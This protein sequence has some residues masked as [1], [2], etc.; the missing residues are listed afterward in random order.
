MPSIIEGYNYDIFISYRQKDNKGDR[1]VSE[2]VEALKTELESTFKEE[3]S[4]YFDINPHDG[5]LETHDV[6]ASL[7]DK[8]KCLVFIPIIS[9]TY[10]DTKSFAWENE[11]KAFINQTSN[12]PY[13]LKINVSGGN[14]TNR[15][16]PVQIH[17]L[18]AE[19]KKLVESELGGHLRGIEFIYKES[20]V[21]RPLAPNDDEKKNLNGLKYK[22]QINKVANAIN[23]IIDGIK[24]TDRSGK[25]ISDK[26]TE[27]KPSEKIYHRTKIITGAL[28]IL[29]LIVAG[30]F[31]VPKLIRPQEQLDK[32]IAVLPF[33]LLSDEP[34]KQYLADGMMDAI[35]LYLS[36]I[37]D[38]RVITR[39]S[40][41]QYRGSTKAPHVIG[42]ELD[43]EYLLEG[44][45]QK[46]GDNVRLI[47]Q[48]I[49]ANEESHAWANEY[50]RNW[51]DIFSVQSEVAQAI[52][53]E[54]HTIITPQ[55]KIL[56]EKIPTS[57]ME[58][59]DAFLKGYFF[60]EKLD[61]VEVE[62]KKATFWFKESIK[63]DSAFS[64][65]WTYLS[66]CYWR[67][68]STS[69]APEFKEAE[70]AAERALALDPT[71]GT[72]IVN[73]ATIL[74]NQYD[75]EGAEEKTRLAMKID[76]DNQYVLR[77]AGRFYTLLGRKDESITLCNL[78][79][80]NDPNNSTALYYLA[81]AY[82]YSGNFKEAW[83]ILNK[84]YALENKGLGTLYYQ[85]LL[86]EGNLDRII[87]EPGFEEDY[88][89]RNI[90]LA[91][92]N[93]RLEHKNVAEKIC[94]DLKEKNIPFYWIAFAY[95]YGDEPEKV[96]EYLE[97]S[98]AL[99]E[100]QLTYLGVEP[101]FKKFRNEPRMKIL[102]QKMKFPV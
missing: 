87:N 10:C 19:D 23:E 37:K 39:T 43:V 59:Y 80:K 91:A 46:F 63:L 41:E 4:V 58:A 34:D 94:N 28:I 92:V 67:L 30:Y 57:N 12:D 86:A 9:R 20:G 95:T 5:L 56:I 8:L 83:T 21:N 74:D 1:W 40:V 25:V 62:N 96:Y 31:M 102:F 98:Y 15:V 73:M 79:L 16:L 68:A 17:E 13:G 65:P 6:D 24:N 89:A 42:K 38:L 64:L 22:N 75:F 54:L 101:A 29:A 52:A 47:V 72:A 53:G 69:L 14:V 55:E 26:I 70:N 51:K 11:F 27:E 7:K 93:F 2:F 35:T 32:S 36:R 88:N 3:I 45:F 49:K 85:L 99:R 66:M 60:Y 97:R 100:K 76:P 82:F 18:N 44:S 78:A 50:N 61:S 71:S 90:G 33:K 48:L 84:Y 81:L 77:N